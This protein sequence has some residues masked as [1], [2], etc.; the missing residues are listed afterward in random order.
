[1]KKLVLFLV[2]SLLS[3]N[4][5]IAQSTEDLVTKIRRQYNEVSSMENNRQS[6]SCQ[7][8]SSFVYRNMGGQNMKFPQSA[9]KCTY[10]GG[11][12]IITSKFE[13]WEF[14]ASAKFYFLNGQLFFVF[15]NV[16]NVASGYEYRTYYNNGSVI[17]VLQKGGV[18][19]EESKVNQDVTYNSDG[20]WVKKFNSER[21]RQSVSMLK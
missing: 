18:F 12:T 1:M 7:N 17:R 3:I 15:A 2:L 5:L 4:Q 6:I 19:G 8:G 13:D 20:S 21:L 16:S 11:Y 9:K 14:G 10:P